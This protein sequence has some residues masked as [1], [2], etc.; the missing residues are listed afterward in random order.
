MSLA[1]RALIVDDEAPMRQLLEAFVRREGFEVAAA[2]DGRQVLPWLRPGLA[3]VALVDRRMPGVD[4]LEVLAAIRATDP[5]CQVALITGDPTVDSA[6]QAVKGGA[7]DYLSKPLEPGRL[8]ALLAAVREERGRRVAVLAS[9]SALA[10]R[11]ELCGMV[12]RSP[13]M[14]EMFTM[15]RRVAAHARTVL[16]SGETGTGKEMVARALHALG[17]RASRRMVTVNCSAIV[18]TLFEGEVFG[19]VRGAFTGATADRAGLFEAASGGT[20]LLDEVG[21]LPLPLQAKLLRALESGEILRV[22]ATT[23][24]P[25][26]VRLVALTNRDLGAEVAAGRFRSDLFYRLD[27]AHLTVPPLRER[28]EDVPFL[29]ARFVEEFARRFDKPLEGLTAEAERALFGWHWPGNVRELRNTL[30]RACLTSEGGL[31]SSK[32]LR[33]GPGSGSAASPPR[34]GTLAALERERIGDVLDECGG[35]KAEAARRLGIDRRS[36]YR[37]IDQYGLAHVREPREGTS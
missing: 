25:V 31:L 6:V 4:G 15:I 37:R 30:E 10:R 21:E 22:G 28:I 20:L 14:Q 24:V 1:L 32:D 11:L 2:G 27:I 3:D 33:L 35:N 12:G 36:L 8:K 23:A 16:V 34:Q 9:E 29:T 26:D 5:E 18:E 19:H 13:V 7:I 17:P